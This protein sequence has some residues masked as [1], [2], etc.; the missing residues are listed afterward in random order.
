MPI[1]LRSPVFFV[2]ERVTVQGN[3]TS[4]TRASTVTYHVQCDSATP[5]MVENKAQT[6]ALVKLSDGEG[7][8]IAAG[9]MLGKC[10][11]SSSF[12]THDF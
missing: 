1:R 6:R 11:V 12:A 9:A 5:L 4:A 3:P 7:A 10:L 8:R 2:R